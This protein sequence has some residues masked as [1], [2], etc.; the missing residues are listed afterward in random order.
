MSL[1]KCTECKKKIS[2]KAENCPHCGCPVTANKVV[3]NPRKTSFTV[4]LLLWII[5]Y[6]FYI[7]ML[8]PVGGILATLLII[9]F[10]S[11][12]KYHDKGRELF[13][14]F[15]STKLFVKILILGVLALF[16]FYV[17][18]TGEVLRQEQV[19]A[20]QEAEQAN[21]TKLKNL[22]QELKQN[23]DSIINEANAYASS[24]NF[25][26]AIN[27]LEK[28]RSVSSE[29]SDKI[30]VYKAEQD[31]LDYESKVQQ[32]LAKIKTLEEESN[33]QEV[34]KISENLKKNPEI[35]IAYD[36]ASQKIAEEKANNLVLEVKDSFEAKDF[37]KVISKSRLY[38]DNNE[39]LE[40][41]F[42]K[43]VKIKSGELLSELKKVP[44]SDAKQNLDLYRKLVSLNPEN[45]SYK[46]KRDKYSKAHHDAEAKRKAKASAKLELIKWSWGQSYSHAIA[47]G[48]VKNLTG[49]SLKN[50]QA[51]VTFKDKDGNFITSSD[52]LIEYNP[53]LANQSSPFK[54]YA[55]WNPVM[56]KASIEFKQMFGGTVS[57]FYDK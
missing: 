44:A 50:I 52:A 2:D 3:A 1:I 28:Y 11:F 7:V 19:V 54:V 6:F 37:D 14:S 34:V 26:Q 39:E 49:A 48:H 38:K 25:T 24:N 15:A 22:K 32:T 9:G 46:A 31:K 35:K 45:Q 4:K 17:R 5:G 8:P 13:S 30:K 40:K 57:H 16:L 33:Y 47:E 36:T 43:A 23:K 18:Y 55:T 41:Y 27:K 51:V 29:I 12:A 42:T 21:K 10:V 53:V 20:K 56:S